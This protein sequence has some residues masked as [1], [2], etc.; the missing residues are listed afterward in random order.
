RG[1]VVETACGL[2]LRAS[3]PGHPPERVGRGQEPPAGARATVVVRP[4]RV[5][6][7]APDAAPED[8]FEARVTNVTYLGDLLFYELRAG[9]LA[10][11]AEAP[12]VH[13]TVAD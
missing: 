12:T 8:A 6:L 9:E 2:R 13:R 3:G 5:H 1:L 10:L 7:A 4:H 11:T